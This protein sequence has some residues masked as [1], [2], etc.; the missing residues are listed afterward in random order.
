MSKKTG[1]R[2]AKKNTTLTLGEGLDRSLDAMFDAINDH[3]EQIRL[4]ICLTDA[5]R[6]HLGLDLPRDSDLPEGMVPE[7]VELSPEEEA[8]YGGQRLKGEDE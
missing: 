3:D 2:I 1:S 6:E 4:L 8:F 5:I 7:R